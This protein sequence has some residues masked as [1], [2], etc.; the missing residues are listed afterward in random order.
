MCSVG[1]YMRVNGCILCPEGTVC[2]EI[3]IMHSL[4]FLAS[5]GGAEVVARVFGRIRRGGAGGGWQ[6]KGD[7]AKVV[8]I[9]FT[10]QDRERERVEEGAGGNMKCS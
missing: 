10:I 5:C 2:E 7:K 6:M 9:Y 4:P 8:P 3:G 1:Y